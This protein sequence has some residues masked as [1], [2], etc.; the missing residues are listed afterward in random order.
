MISISAVMLKNKLSS[1]MVYKSFIHG[2]SKQ[3]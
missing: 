3:T 2:H 1:C